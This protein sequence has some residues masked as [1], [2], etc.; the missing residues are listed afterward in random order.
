M[1]KVEEAATARR[2]P[3]LPLAISAALGAI[4]LISIF[5][6]PV[7]NPASTLCGFRTL[8]GLPCVACGMTRS[9]C[10]IAKGEIIAGFDFN[11]LGPPLF[12]I[13]LLVWLAA[14]LALVGRE[15][16]FARLMMLI[17][18]VRV[19]QSSLIILALYWVVRII[20]LLATEGSATTI[21]KGLIARLWQG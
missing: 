20:L 2:L 21:N 3:L 15:K 7:A 12:L 9:F 14:T 4:L 18:D 1:D 19:M 13:I 5:H 16:F 6:H 8:F 11:L 10:A 17:S